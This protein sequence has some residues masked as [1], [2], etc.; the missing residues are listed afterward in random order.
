MDKRPTGIL[1]GTAGERLTSMSTLELYAN[2]RLAQAG[3]GDFQGLVPT[4]RLLHRMEAELRDRPLQD[5]VVAEARVE[6]LM[7][8]DR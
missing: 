2:L 1:L 4:E 5:R 6:A 8:D 3:D 7:H